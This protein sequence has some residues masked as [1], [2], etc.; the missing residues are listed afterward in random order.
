MN[1]VQGKVVVKGSGAGIADLQVVIYDIDPTQL[2]QQFPN[3]GN[4][5]DIRSIF[6]LSEQYWRSWINFPGD[7]IGSVLTNA[8]GYFELKYEDSEFQGRN[9]ERRPD[10]VLFVLAPDESLDGSSLEGLG[11]SPYQR[12]L[13]LALVPRAN[14]GRVESY[15]I[16][17][18]PSI[19]DRFSIRYPGARPHPTSE[20]NH[21]I[22]MVR[23]KLR[24][25]DA[26]G[27]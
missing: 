21:L 2:D 18:K 1:I 7:R 25:Y 10:L 9:T 20:V 14:A 11:Q 17:I 24:G 15:S 27:A 16:A 8:R 22:A 12:I 3:S 4:D 23:T 26:V 6:L 13:H 5:D 19:L